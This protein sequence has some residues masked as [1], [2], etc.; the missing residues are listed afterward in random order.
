[1][2]KGTALVLWDRWRRLHPEL[3]PETDVGLD[4]C[5]DELEAAARQVVERVR[6]LKLAGAIADCVEREAVLRILREAGLMP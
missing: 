2:S 6:A 5:A 1:M 4:I 3:S